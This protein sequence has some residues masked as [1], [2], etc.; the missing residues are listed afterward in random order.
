[1]GFEAY[2]DEIR[3]KHVHFH[4]HLNCQHIADNGG[5]IKF[6]LL[7]SNKNTLFTLFYVEIVSIR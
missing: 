2:L 1:M 7:E 4:Y 6:Q 5:D 3:K